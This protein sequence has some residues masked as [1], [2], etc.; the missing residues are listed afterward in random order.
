MPRAQSA[1]LGKGPEMRAWG[2]SPLESMIVQGVDRSS[3]IL[4]LWKPS[5]VSPTGWCGD[6]GTDLLS[7]L[8]VCP[9]IPRHRGLCYRISLLGALKEHVCGPFSELLD[10]TKLSLRRNGQDRS[11]ENALWKCR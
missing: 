2:L 5:P 1:G 4:Q 7:S 9:Q 8:F 6:R 3:W 10:N 11:I